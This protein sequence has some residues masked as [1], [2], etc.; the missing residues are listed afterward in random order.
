MNIQS[1][2][3]LKNTFLIAMP[4]MQ[5]TWFGQS[6][7]L[8]CEHSQE[9]AMGIVVNKPLGMQLGELYEQIDIP[10]ANMNLRSIPVFKG[11]PVQS[12]RGFILHNYYRDVPGT[13]KIGEDLYLSTSKEVLADIAIGVGPQHFLVALGYAGWGENQLIDEL[14][15]N[16]WLNAP[17][18]PSLIFETPPHQRWE[19][20][21][22]HVGIEIRHLCANVGHA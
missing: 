16:A 4:S 15:A 3:E 5:E 7:V 18:L 22:T 17:V 21:A 8:V 2:Y 13:Q 12:E 10:C 1:A 14:C 20:A 6:L 11:G 19:D 9:A